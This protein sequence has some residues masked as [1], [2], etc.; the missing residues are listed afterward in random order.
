VGGGY[1]FVHR[2][3]QDYFATLANETKG[4]TATGSTPPV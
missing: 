4:Q 1:V 2:L 3:L